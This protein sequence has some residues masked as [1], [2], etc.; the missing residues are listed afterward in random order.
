MAALELAAPARL[1]GADI[2]VPCVDGRE[3]RYV[4]LDY[5]ASAPVMVDVW[6][7]V[8][9]FMPWYSSVHRGSGVKSQV[10]T[11]AFEGAREVVAEFAGARADDDVVFVRNTTEAI[12]VL[13]AALPEGTRVIG[14][15]VE[16]HANLLPWRKHDLRMLPFPRSAEDLLDACE[17]SLR[18]APADIV[19]VTGASNVTGEVWPVA[20]LADDRAPPRRE[21]VRRRRPARAA[22]GDRHGRRGHRLPRASPATSSTR[23]SAPER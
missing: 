14:T 23:R 17:Q 18:A 9:E 8:E 11:A 3:H 13:A 19:A 21:A 10:A 15:P 6:K 4:N 20:E 16:H 12:N 7:A 22:P 5:A 2:Q 1:L